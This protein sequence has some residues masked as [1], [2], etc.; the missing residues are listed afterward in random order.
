MVDVASV[1]RLRPLGQVACLFGLPVD[2]RIPA[3][4]ALGST[5]SPSTPHGFLFA[6]LQAECL[7]T[8]ASVLVRTALRD[9]LVL[10]HD[11]ARRA[12]R[13][14]RDNRHSRGRIPLAE[15]AFREAAT[16]FGVARQRVGG[17]SVTH[18]SVPIDLGEPL[19]G[20]F[21]VLGALGL[22]EGA[23]LAA[24]GGG[25]DWG[26]DQA[27]DVLVRARSTAALACEF[28]ACTD[29]LVASLGIMVPCTLGGVTSFVP[30]EEAV[31]ERLFAWGSGRPAFS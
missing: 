5:W 11:E 23:A 4:I 21:S 2:E 26:R 7:E 18:G 6:S 16:F 15:N 17:Q 28:S 19:L 29:R 3:A 12:S 24:R 13:A 1:G 20:V 9:S 25:L 27:L 8:S 22:V 10:V 14:Y 30:L 31:E